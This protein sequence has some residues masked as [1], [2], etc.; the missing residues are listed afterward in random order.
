MEMGDWDMVEHLMGPEEGPSGSVNTER[1]VVSGAAAVKTRQESVSA[2]GIPMEQGETDAV[3]LQEG[4]QAFP[5][6]KANPN[7]GES[8]SHH[9]LS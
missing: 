4:V 7:T 6:L 5:V 8:S 2:P 1:S 9:A 3:T